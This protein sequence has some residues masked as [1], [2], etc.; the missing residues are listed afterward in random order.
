MDKKYV[1]YNFINEYYERNY[2]N[3]MPKLTSFIEDA[4]LFDL[5]EVK[6]K[7]TELHK[8]GFTGLDYDKKEN[9]YI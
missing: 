1:I 5:H 9:D 4:I 2:D 8:M 3:G 6:I 7:L